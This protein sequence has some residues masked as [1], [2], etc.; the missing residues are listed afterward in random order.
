[1]KLTEAQRRPCRLLMMQI[2]AQIIGQ[3]AHIGMTYEKMADE[4]GVSPQLVRNTLAAMAVGDDRSRRATSIAAPAAMAAAM[5]CFFNVSL[6]PEPLP[7][8]AEGLIG[9]MFDDPA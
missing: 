1:M 8:P 2:A 3:M 9:E 4:L 7:E 5:G 6:I